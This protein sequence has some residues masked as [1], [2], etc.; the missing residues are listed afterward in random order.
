M[1]CIHAT[2]LYSWLFQQWWL[3]T[4]QQFK[5]IQKVYLA[6]LGAWCL[7][8]V[9][10]LNLRSTLY[11]WRLHFGSDIYPSR[12][13]TAVFSI[14]RECLQWLI[15][16]KREKDIASTKPWGAA[17]NQ[18]LRSR[19]GSSTDSLYSLGTESAGKS[20]FLDQL[21]APY[22]VWPSASQLSQAQS[23]SAPF[24]SPFHALTFLS[25]Y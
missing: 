5:L 4:V 16:Q 22:S 3:W 15:S 17:G 2:L 25:S 7:V 11:Q 10:Y 18:H 21:T 12:I 13:L 19:P 6:C 23:S 8:H 14:S 24:H 1:Q 20:Y 9:L